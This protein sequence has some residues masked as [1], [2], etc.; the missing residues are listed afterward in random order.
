MRFFSITMAV[1]L[2]LCAGVAG[3]DPRGTISGRV[4]DPTGSVIP[5]VEIRV[6]NRD[7]NVSA[8]ALSN[9]TGSFT[10]P[11][12]LSGTYRVSAELPGLKKYVRDGIQ[13]RV[14]ETIEL[15]IQMEVGEVTESVTVT[16]ETPLLDTSGS[17]L[18]QVIDQRRV[19]ELPMLAGNPMELTLLTPGVING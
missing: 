6:T 10:V 4:T 13:V 9:D 12:L 16:M 8:T 2:M 11:F 3:Q 19:L 15:N 17:S 5:G 18:G 7:T 14:T 1:W